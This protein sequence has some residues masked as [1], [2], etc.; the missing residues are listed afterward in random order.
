MILSGTPPGPAPSAPRACGRQP[1]CGC[2]PGHGGAWDQTAAETST[3][4]CWPLIFACSAPTSAAAHAPLDNRRAVAYLLNAL[5]EAG[6]SE[7]VTALAARA[8][9]RPPLDNPR[10]VAD[11]L[12]ALRKAGA[13]EQR[14]ALISRL[15]AEGLFQ[16][17]REED[18]QGKY[19]FGREPDREGKPAL[20]W[21]WS[22]LD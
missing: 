11:L 16:L 21:S 13:S 3:A 18:G 8:A 10:V 9:A 4:T 14:A 22:D 12:N 5:R 2:W 20:A 17:F 15:P 19:K 7:Q 1:R 6:A